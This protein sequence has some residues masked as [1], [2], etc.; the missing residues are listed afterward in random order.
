MKKV[1]LIIP[2]YNEEQ[3][4][5]ALLDELTLQYPQYDYLVINDCSKDST[6]DIL[7]RRKATYLDLPVNLGIGGGV[8]AGYIYALENDYDVAVQMDGDGQHLPSYL[9]AIIL[10]V[11][12]GEAD[13]VI[14]SRFLNNE[15]FQS[16]KLR[17]VGIKFLSALIYVV[18]GN[19]ILDVTS[20]F[21]AVNRKCIE[22]FAK[23]Y[24]QDY[25]EPEAL[26]TSAMNDIKILEIPV[27]MK[28]RSNGQS[29][30]NGLKSIYYMVKVSL[31][32]LI[33][34]MKKERR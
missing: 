25:P 27:V 8:Q 9:D 2:A 26:V 13:S 34:G 17:R 11:L 7:K 22:I 19:R 12:N 16:S 10:P 23:T 3:N 15:G 28:E 33:A 6:L 24:A 20:G 5:P 14:G 30:I 1:L 21:R 18:T 31:A 29:S 4:L 32:I